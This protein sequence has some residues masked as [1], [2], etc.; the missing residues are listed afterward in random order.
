MG[1]MPGMPMGMPPPPMMGMMGPGGFPMMGMMPGPPM[2]MGMP[3]PSGG[4]GMS[5]ERRRDRDQEPLDPLDPA[6]VEEMTEYLSV[7]GGCDYGKFS[8][9]FPKVKK[10]QLEEHFHFIT[11]SRG[12]QRIE[13]PRDHPDYREAPQQEEEELEPG[14]VGEE[15]ERPA[16]GDEMNEP[17]LEGVGDMSGEDPAIR[18]SVGCQPHGTI[19]SYDAAKGFGF[20]YVEGMDEDIYFPR[21]A[22]PD[23]FHS[24]RRTEMPELLGVEVSIELG[25]NSDRG[26]RASRLH[27][28]LRWHTD[29][30]CWLLKRH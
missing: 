1:G 15:E 28:L 2:G 3:P 25:E 10:R 6:V 19:R 17:P 22:L 8:R 5:Y 9:R 4:S 27:F 7:E 18:P 20:V 16:S 24:K 13:L 11:G 30:K 23:T 29:D 12:S 14:I 21:S 26:P